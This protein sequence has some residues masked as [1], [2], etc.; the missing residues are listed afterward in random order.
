MIDDDLHHQHISPQERFDRLHSLAE[1][2]AKLVARRRIIAHELR[3]RAAEL[4]A[5]D[6]QLADIDQTEAWLRDSQP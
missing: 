6:R 5:I 4:D 2:R 3:V 1:W